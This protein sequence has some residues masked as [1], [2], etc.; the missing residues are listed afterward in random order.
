MSIF[1]RS[2]GL[3]DFLPY[4]SHV[5]PNVIR[6]SGGDYLCTWRIEGLPFAGRDDWELEGKHESFNRLLQTLRA[7]DYL[8]VSFWTHDIRTRTRAELGENF[9]HVF[10]KS[11]NDKYFNQLNKNRLM[12]NELHLTLIYRPNGPQ[13]V[14]FKSQVLEIDHIRQDQDDAVSKTLEFARSVQA[15]LSDFD[16]RLLGTYE[17]GAGIVFS[18]NLSFLG[19]LINHV[20]EEIPVLKAPIYNYLSTSSH[21]FNEKSGNHLIKTANNVSYFGTMLI[22]KEYPDRTFPGILN[23]LKNLNFEYVLT[24]SFSPMGK[25]DSL[26]SLSTTKA[27]MIS[28]QDKAISQ[29]EDLDKAMDGL[30]SGNFIFGE[31]HFSLAIYGATLKALDDNLAEIRSVLSSAGFV[32]AREDMASMSA[33]YA[34]LPCNWNFR[35]RKTMT[36]SLNF[37]GLSPL[38][39][40]SVGKKHQNPWGDAVTALQTTNGQP[41]YFNFHASKA[42]ENSSGEKV[43]GNTMVIGK[44]GTGKTAL[45]NFLLSQVQKLDPKPTIFFFDKDRG[46]EIFVRACGGR[47]LAIKSGEP[48]GFN[49]FQCEATEENN[50]FLV[51]MIKLLAEKDKYSAGEDEDILRAVKAILDSPMHLRSL[52]NLQTSLPNLG[53]DSVYSRL[54]KWTAAGYL[55]WVFDNADDKIKFDTSNIIGFDYTDLIDLAEV[56]VPVILYLIHR[57]EELIDGR[58]LIYVMDEFWKILDGEGG[59][60]EFARNKLKTIRKQNGLGIF[61]TQSPEDALKSDIAATLVEQTATLILLPNPSA[62]KTDYMDGLKLSEAEFKQLVELDENSRSFIIKQGHSSVVC[63]LQLGGMPDELAVISASTD[64]I[65]I[66]HRLIDEAIKEAASKDDSSNARIPSS[67]RINNKVNDSLFKIVDPDLWL[68]KF[69]DQRKGLGKNLSKS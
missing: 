56:R 34:Q 6:T 50:L 17:S 48:T 54:K 66:M 52:T 44:S 58:P 68:P 69:Y 13:G 60:K 29:I 36:T 57:L 7:P 40:F 4:S 26:S 9:E 3:G 28:S 39:N 8:N 67:F 47:Y 24:H 21:T 33:F 16:P 45:I 31:Y 14:G 1:S 63:Q 42:N 27:R 18:E 32:T 49:P 2:S 15:V 46:A 37:L 41:Y 30:S 38:H 11:L 20:Y 25:Q 62:S 59:L 55:G 51:S 65:V 22:L 64:N 35:V 12:S 5:H 23:G 43:L 10:N 61:A 19:Y 53:D